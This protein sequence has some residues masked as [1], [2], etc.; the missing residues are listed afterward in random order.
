LIFLAKIHR[1]D[2]LARLYEEV[3]IP[4]SVM[5][6][7]KAKPDQEM[8]RIQALLQSQKF[9]LRKATEQALEGLPAD[10]GSGEQEAIA[11]ALETEADLVKLDDQQGRRIARER[12]LPV[13]GTV[14]VL[15]EARGRGMIPSVHHELDR[16]IE[17][18]MWVDEAFYHRILLEFGELSEQT[19]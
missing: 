16:L 4:V 10:L 5:E 13:S 1:L 19:A 9:R 14:G 17:A 8:E 11:L 2:L 3:V 12:G 7:V 6:E 18:G 15:V